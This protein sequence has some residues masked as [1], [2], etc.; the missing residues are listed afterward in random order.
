MIVGLIMG[1]QRDH[2]CHRREHDLRAAFREGDAKG[3]RKRLQQ[4]DA[5]RPVGRRLDGKARPL[6]RS[7]VES[8]EENAKRIKSDVLRAALDSSNV[9]N[10]AIEPRSQPRLGE[11]QRGALLANRSANPH[12]ENRQATP[13]HPNSAP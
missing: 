1:L 11:T 10:V 13:L 9:V 5:R 4:S 2:G 7:G 8:G 12:M 3:I 6:A